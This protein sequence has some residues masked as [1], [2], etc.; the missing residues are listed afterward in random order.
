MKLIG[1]VSILP[2]CTYATFAQMA[3]DYLKLQNLEDKRGLVNAIGLQAFEDIDGYGCWCYFE[4]DHGLGR[5]QAQDPIDNHCRTTH[6]GYSCAIMDHGSTG[7]FVFGFFYLVIF[8]RFLDKI[9]RYNE[10][11]KNSPIDETNNFHFVKLTTYF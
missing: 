2:A 1:L 6:D 11:L 7:G 3:A 9:R 8:C 5:G 4:D 10:I